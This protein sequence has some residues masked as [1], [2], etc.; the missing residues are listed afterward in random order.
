M[1]EAEHEARCGQ[2][3]RDTCLAAFFIREKMA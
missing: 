2:R 1:T 3:T